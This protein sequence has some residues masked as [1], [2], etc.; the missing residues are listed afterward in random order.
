MF[1]LPDIGKHFRYD[2][3][4][5]GCAIYKKIVLYSKF[6]EM[7]YLNITEKFKKKLS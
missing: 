4:Q 6:Q 2:F 5:K 7:K 3:E 1:T